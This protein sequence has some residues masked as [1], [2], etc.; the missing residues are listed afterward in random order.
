M[1]FTFLGLSGADNVPASTPFDVVI[2]EKQVFGLCADLSSF[3]NPNSPSSKVVLQ[4][5]YFA[6]YEQV[7]DVDIY[8]GSQCRSIDTHYNPNSGNVTKIC[9]V[10]GMD[11]WNYEGSMVIRNVCQVM[12]QWDVVDPMNWFVNFQMS[13]VKGHSQEIPDCNVVI[14]TWKIYTVE[15]AE[16]EICEFPPSMYFPTC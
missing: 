10:Q 13:C 15:T 16:D 2:P 12:D 4:A 8:E 9:S 3:Y 11:T 14:D 1:G 6:K 5:S 7:Y